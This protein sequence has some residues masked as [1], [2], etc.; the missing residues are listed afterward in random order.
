MS[1]GEIIN[2][3]AIGFDDHDSSIE[4]YCKECGVVKTG[5]GIS[6]LQSA[7][8]KNV[9]ADCPNCGKMG[10]IVDGDYDFERQVALLLSDTKVNRQQAR[11]FKR[12]A[13]KT[14]SI[15]NLA[16]QAKIIDPRFAEIVEL[17]KKEEKPHS[18]IQKAAGIAVFVASIAGGVIAFDEIWDRYLNKEL[19]EDHTF[20]ESDGFEEQANS[21]PSGE[22]KN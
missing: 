16:F 10:K 14:S 8:L 18:V 12:K 22:A 1:H 15:D 4:M 11:R 3:T 21:K 9:R 19:F 5:L 17:A 2:Y 6:G 20:V 13:E 7:S